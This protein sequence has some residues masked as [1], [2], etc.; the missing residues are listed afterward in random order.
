MKIN[1][2]IYIAIERY[3]KVKYL[4]PCFM[5]TIY[6]LVVVLYQKEVIDKYNI[7][8]DKSLKVCED[9]DFFFKNFCVSKV[10]FIPEVLA[11]Y[12]RFIKII[13]HQNTLN[14]FL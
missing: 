4:T 1:H 12:R 3:I 10:D 13:S 5:T 11:M 9:L 7:K 8:F 14:Y 6:V 2:L